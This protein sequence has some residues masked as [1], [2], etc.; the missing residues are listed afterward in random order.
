MNHFKMAQ[1]SIINTI[2]KITEALVEL[3]KKIKY[4]KII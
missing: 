3:E 1:K 4:F 2:S